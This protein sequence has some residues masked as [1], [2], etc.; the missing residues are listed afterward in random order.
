MVYGVEVQSEGSK[1]NSVFKQLINCQTNVQGEKGLGTTKQR[2][3]NNSF[4]PYL[5][6]A[7]TL[8]STVALALYTKIEGLVGLGLT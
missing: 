7:L 3:Q 6:T 1:A 2:K 5:I 8:T 4:C